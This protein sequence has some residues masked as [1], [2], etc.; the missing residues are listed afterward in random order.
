MQAT[1]E[2]AQTQKFTKIFLMMHEKQETWLFPYWKFTF[3]ELTLNVKD[4]SKCRYMYTKIL[5]AYL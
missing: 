3:L 5:V 4:T 2:A 1:V